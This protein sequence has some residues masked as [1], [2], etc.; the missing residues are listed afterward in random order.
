MRDTKFQALGM[1]I[2]PL[3]I[4]GAKQIEETFYTKVKTEKIGKGR[5]LA[6]LKDIWRVFGEILPLQKSNEKEKQKTSRKA[7]EKI[8]NTRFSYFSVAFPCFCR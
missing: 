7:K 6:N 4:D 5:I 8:I 1:V 3:C 2:I